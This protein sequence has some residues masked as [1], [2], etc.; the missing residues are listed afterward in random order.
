MNL[1]RELPYTCQIPDVDRP[2]ELPR[3][4]L[5]VITEIKNK[6]YISYVSIK[7]VIYVKKSK[8]LNFFIYYR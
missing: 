3:N 6:I 1:L 5:V 8:I 7:T 2:H 4:V